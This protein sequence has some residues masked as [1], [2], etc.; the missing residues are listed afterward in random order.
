MIDIKEKWIALSLIPGVGHVKFRNLINHFGSPDRVFDASLDEL[1]MVEGVD[2][3][4][5]NAIVQHNI[6]VDKELKLIKENNVKIITIQDDEYPLNL[7]FTFDPPVILYVK[8]TLINEDNV[9]IAI[10]GSRRATSYGK[11]VAEKL[12]SELAQN[13]IT[14]VS[15][16]ARGVDTF[17]HKGALLKDGRTIAVLGSGLSVVYPPENKGLAE[18]IAQKG[19]I[20]SEFSM[21]TKPERGNFPIRNRLISGL[22]LGTVVVEAAQESGALITAGYA[23]EQG[24]EIFAVPNNI[25]NKYSKGTHKLIKQGAKLTEDVN[26]IIEEIESFRQAW[27]NPKKSFEKPEEH[28]KLSVDECQVYKS[29]SYEPLYIDQIAEKNNLKINIL[30]SVL[31]GLEMKGKIKQLSGKRFVRV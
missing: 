12:G 28:S 7:K 31:V 14:V 8:G 30:S 5:A 19:A 13:G 22:T 24:R 1:L 2:R 9:S 23:L 17:A 29:I 18:K 25:F 6:D 4:I 15:G 27:K 16:L 11:M 26:D 10:V 20:L 3:G 21:T